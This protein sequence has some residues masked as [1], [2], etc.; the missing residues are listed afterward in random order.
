M[1]VFTGL[2]NS[3]S[4]LRFYNKLK[5]VILYTS[6]KGDIMAKFCTN[7]GSAMEDNRTTCPVCGKPVENAPFSNNFVQPSFP[8]GLEEPMSLGSWVITLILSVIPIVGLI[9]LIVW[10]VSAE[11]VNK[12]NFARA[13]LIIMIAVY[14]IVFLGACASALFISGINY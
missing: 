3:L 9:M 4:F 8:Q 13:N 14:V 11:S 12:R 5:A 6:R 1:Q 2:I 7:C 10:A